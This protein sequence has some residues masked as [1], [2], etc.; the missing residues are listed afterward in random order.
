MFFLNFMKRK[1]GNFCP[2]TKKA[3][4]PLLVNIGESGIKL[5]RKGISYLKGTSSIFSPVSAI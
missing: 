2:K 1:K 3:V 4:S 5:Y